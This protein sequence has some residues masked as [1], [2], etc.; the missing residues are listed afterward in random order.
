MNMLKKEKIRSTNWYKQAGAAIP[1]CAFLPFLTLSSRRMV[2]TTGL[3]FPYDVSMCLKTSS[4]FSLYHYFDQ[5]RALPEVKKILSHV[6]AHDHFFESHYE[7]FITAGKK[8]EKSG[9]N[10]I[11]LPVSS[12]TFLYTYQDFLEQSF[13][14]W[15]HSIFIDLLDPFDKEIISFI[16]GSKKNKLTQNDL[17][18]LLGPDNLPLYMQEQ[19]DFLTIVSL[20]Q[21]YKITSSNVK[22]ALKEHA[23]RYFWLKNDY[24]KVYFLDSD[25]YTK[26]LVDVTYHKEKITLIQKTLDTFTKNRALKQQKIQKYDL[27]L[28]EKDRLRF[29]SWISEFRDERKKYNQISNYYIISVMEKIANE[30]NLDLE[31]L[32]Y[33]L[34]DEVTLLLSDTAH[35]LSTLQKRTKGG[36]MISLSATPPQKNR[37]TIYSGSVVKEY[38]TLIENSIAKN[39]TVAGTCASFGKASGKAKIIL[40]QEDFSKMNTGDI[41]IAPMTRPEYVPIMKKASAIVTDEGGLTCHAAIIARELQI[42]CII[43]TQT[44]TKTIAHG[45]I[46]KVDANLGIVTI[47]QKKKKK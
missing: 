42:P 18:I 34:P 36:V 33:T 25:Y 21:K 31:L 44:A 27:T 1:L 14:F 7:H 8:M 13:T 20:A 29:F 16:F 39:K 26:K 46:I 4:G 43:G 12:E 23:K 10:L 40:N 35:I 47:I 9:L 5:T 24:E 11:Q 37:P 3:F 38:H 28:E 32:K 41:L 15:Q 22:K 30:K 19:K 17:H 2:V 6:K 45:D